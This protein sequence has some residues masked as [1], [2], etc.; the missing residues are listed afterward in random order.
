MEID[1]Y[2]R[3]PSSNFQQK[4]ARKIYNKFIHEL[5]IMPVPISDDIRKAIAH[6]I[7]DPNAGGSNDTIALFQQASNLVRRYIELY[8]FSKF[9]RTNDINKVIAILADDN[10]DVKVRSFTLVANIT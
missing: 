8:Q 3:I 2:F 6:S 9:L 1:E 7:D 5:A 10:A 4:Q